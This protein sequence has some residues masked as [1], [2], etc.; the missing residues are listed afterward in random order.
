MGGSGGHDR[1]P[2]RESQSFSRQ[3]AQVKEALMKLSPQDPEYEDKAADLLMMR[4][5]FEETQT[6]T[7]EEEVMS[8]FSAKL[9]SLD[10]VLQ[11]NQ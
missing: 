6:H 5:Y 10:R 2:T 1:G 8:H 11:R 3:A 7:A 4:K 9:L